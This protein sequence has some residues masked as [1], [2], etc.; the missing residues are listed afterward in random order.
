MLTWFLENIIWFQILGF[1]ISAVFCVL[2]VRL[3]IKMDYFTSS[4]QYSFRKLRKQPSTSTV[5]TGFWKRVLKHINSKNPQD[6][7]RAVKDA[8]KIFDEALKSVGSHGKDIEERIASADKEATGSLD[9]IIRLRK[10]ILPKLK[11]EVAMTHGEAKE[12]L[13]AY[14]EVLKK[15]EILN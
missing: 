2:T 15:T 5:M 12:I 13:R 10:E 11:D 9:E 7:K 8:D 1:L 6:W 3:M 4:A 14:R